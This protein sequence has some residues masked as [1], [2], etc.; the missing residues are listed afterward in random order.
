MSIGGER[1]GNYEGS[2]PE[3]SGRRYY[4]CDVDY[5]GG[6]RGAE[7]IIYSSDGLIYYTEDHYRTFERLY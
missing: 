5:S 7:R 3:K 1:F 6:Y 4:E 2:L